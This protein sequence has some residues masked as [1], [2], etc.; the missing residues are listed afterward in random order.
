MKIKENSI[1]CQINWVTKNY[2]YLWL[3]IRL[4]LQMENKYIA[5]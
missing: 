4:N 2:D 5:I 1:L 3:V